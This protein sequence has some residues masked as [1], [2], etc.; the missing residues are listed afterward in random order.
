[1]TMITPVG[2]NGKPEDIL[3]I[4]EKHFGR[5]LR[6][7]EEVIAKFEIE[8]A[9]APKEAV[10]V[11]RDL[12]KALQTAFDERA[13]VEKLRKNRTGVVHDYALDFD[14]A[15]DEI[16]RRMARLRAARS[17]GGVSE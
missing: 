6:Q 4:A 8:N 14:A 2:D 17:A 9:T 3:L 11:I 15:R 5:M 12:S 7:A 16:G 1:M 10:I 13:K